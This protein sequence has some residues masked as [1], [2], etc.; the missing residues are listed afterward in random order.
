MKSQFRGYYPPSTDEYATLWAEGTV[1]LDTNSLLNLYRYSEGTGLQFL[2]VLEDLK[3]RLWIPA[4]VA[5]EFLENRLGVIHEQTSA[6]EKVREALE[7]SR[8]AFRVPV[9]HFKRHSSLDAEHLIQ[10]F[11]ESLDMVAVEISVSEKGHRLTVEQAR[12][13]DAVLSVVTS[14]YEGRVG[15]EFT[16]SELAAVYSEGAKR[17]AADVPPG[18]KDSAK[19]D[20]GKYGDLVIWK[21]ILQKAEGARSSAIFVTDDGKE[22]WWRIFHGQRLGPRPELVDEYFSISGKR[23]H[24]YSPEQFL[25]EAQS[26]FSLGLTEETIGEVEE[27]S[28]QSP[29]RLKHVAERRLVELTARRE[30]LLKVIDRPSPRSRRTTELRSKRLAEREG[31]LQ[32]IE[33]LEAAYSSQIREAAS[34]GH[35]DA[36]STGLGM[37]RIQSETRARLLRVDQ[38]LAELDEAPSGIGSQHEGFLRQLAILDAE[39][40]ETAEALAEYEGNER[41]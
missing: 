1:I 35:A 17:Y 18:Y 14:L 20:P 13:A 37:R 5:R 32:Q 3:E 7:S 23:V 11:E 10:L 9:S 24:F 36:E 6:Y 30:N 38:G 25:R 41:V 21:Q 34:Q 33:T 2:N 28:T 39:L 19:G 27:V 12:E 4:Q 40:S 31:L 29:E 8:K 22:D 15:T 26:R 16:A